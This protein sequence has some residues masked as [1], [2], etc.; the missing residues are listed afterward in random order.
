MRGF[1]F[2]KYFYVV[3]FFSFLKK[4]MS[5]QFMLYVWNFI[6]KDTQLYEF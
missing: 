6:Q 1:F 2:F 5:H 3:Y 4:G